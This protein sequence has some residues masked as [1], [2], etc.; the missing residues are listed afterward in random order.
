MEINHEKCMGCEACMV[1][2][3][4]DGY[5]KILLLEQNETD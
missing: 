2:C 4:V 1:Y 3:T 5:S